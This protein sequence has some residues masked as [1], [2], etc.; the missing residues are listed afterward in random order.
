MLTNRPKRSCYTCGNLKGPLTP[1]PSCSAVQYCSDPHSSQDSKRHAYKCARIQ[2]LRDLIRLIDD[3]SHESEGLDD[4]ELQETTRIQIARIFASSSGHLPSD[5]GV[6]IRQVLIVTYLDVNT[7]LSLLLSLDTIKQVHGLLSRRWISEVEDGPFHRLEHQPW[8]RIDRAYI[9]A[10]TAMV[11]LGMDEQCYRYIRTLG[12]FRGRCV[13]E[14]LITMDGVLGWK[15]VFD[16]ERGLGGEG[17]DAFTDL[18]EWVFWNQIP[19]P[20]YIVPIIILVHW[21]IT[22]LEELAKA[23]EVGKALAR[24]LN[25][26]VVEVIKVFVLDTEVVRKRKE[27]LRRDNSDLIAGLQR[28][29]EYFLKISCFQNPD[30]WRRVANAARTEDFGWPILSR[31]KVVPGSRVADMD[32]EELEALYPLVKNTPGLLEY[33]AGFFQKEK[34]FERFINGFNGLD[35]IIVWQNVGRLSD[36]RDESL[37]GNKSREETV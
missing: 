36:A 29:R 25:E 35:R 6:L 1:C 27:L 16:T 4:D 17:Y 21:W 5:L 26:D 10:T 30:F 11:R 9:L 13:E 15:R 12:Q 31:R 32:I 19:R 33:I 7:E 34:A 22:D 28:Q 2:L 14:K 20:C 3:A 23:Q 24:R 37:Q 18:K 8:K